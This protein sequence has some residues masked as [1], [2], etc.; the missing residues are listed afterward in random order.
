MDR[1]YIRGSRLCV[2]CDGCVVKCACIY[3]GVSNVRARKRVILHIVYVVGN[4][5]VVVIVVVAI[6]LLLAPIAVGVV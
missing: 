5:I 4:A 2:L 6:L 1:I 3:S